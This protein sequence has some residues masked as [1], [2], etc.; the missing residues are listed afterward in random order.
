MNEVF[1][2]LVKPSDLK[3]DATMQVIMDEVL[4]KMSEDMKICMMAH[5]PIEVK[6]DGD[7]IKIRTKRKVS[8]LRMPDGKPYHVLI[9]QR[10]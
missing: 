10:E 8:I 4:S 1:E 3:P 5:V 9:C 7:I 6:L 2:L